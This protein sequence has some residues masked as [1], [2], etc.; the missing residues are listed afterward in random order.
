MHLKNYVVLKNDTCSIK[1]C[2]DLNVKCLSFMCG[3]LWPKL[4]ALF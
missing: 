4:L 2:Y 1:D 3:T